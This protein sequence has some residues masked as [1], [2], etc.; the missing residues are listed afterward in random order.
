MSLGC[1][2][3]SNSVSINDSMPHYDFSSLV[4]QYIES[5]YNKQ[6]KSLV[7]LC[8]GTDRST[9]D[10]LGPLIG[11]KIKSSLS[12]YSN[13][14]V[15]GTLDDPV[16]A[17]NLEE[18]I[19]HIKSSCE[20]PFIIA[21]DA[22]LGS[23]DRIGCI[24]IGLGP[25]KPGTGVNKQLPSIGDLHI[26]GIVNIGGYMQYMVLQSTRLSLVMKMADTISDAITFSLWN[27][28]KKMFFHYSVQ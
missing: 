27:L 24:N 23:V 10:S 17:K 15:F 4:T 20:S 5:Y 3:I 13:T 8:I 22:C 2:K 18:T 14:Y 19:S 16:H 25:L 12:K 9:G 6:Y 21:I 7:F 26:T 1:P 28:N 11:Y